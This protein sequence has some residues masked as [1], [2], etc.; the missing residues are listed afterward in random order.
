MIENMGETT[1]HN[2]CSLIKLVIKSLLK[3]VVHYNNRP[4][5]HP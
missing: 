3:V 2:V 5:V 4:L 1:S